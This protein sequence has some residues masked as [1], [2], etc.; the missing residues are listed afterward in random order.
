MF[1]GFTNPVRAYLTHS[2]FYSKYTTQEAPTR[3]TN[4]SMGVNFK[5]AQQL[6][7]LNIQRGL[8][9]ESCSLFYFRPASVY[10]KL[11]ELMINRVV[12]GWVHGIEK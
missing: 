10:S 3:E 6:V 7:L 11:I 9:P 8:L 5:E 1:P 12:G 2:P 4:V